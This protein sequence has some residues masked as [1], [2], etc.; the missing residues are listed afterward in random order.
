M[1]SS[2]RSLRRLGLLLV[3]SVLPPSFVVTVPKVNAQSAEEQENRLA[4]VIGQSEYSGYPL[5]NYNDPNLISDKL[6]EAGFVVEIGKDLEKNSIAEKLNILAEKAQLFGE[7]TTVLVYLSGRFAQIDG[8]NIFLPVG[9]KIDTASSANLNG[10]SINSLISTLKT[11]PVKS[12]VIILDG[13]SPP[14]SLITE[15]MFSPGLVKIEPPEGFLISYNQRPG[16]PLID[17]QEP[18]SPYAQGFLEAMVTPTKDFSDVFQIIRKRVFDQSQGALQP[19]SADNLL[20]KSFSFYKPANGAVSLDQF[21]V[22][23]NDNVDFKS[24]TRDEAYKKVISIDSMQSYQSFITAFPQDEAAEVVKYNLATRREAEVWSRTLQ[25]DTPE[26][27]WTYIQTYPKGN[28]VSVARSRLDRMGEMDSAPPS[29]FQPVIYSD[30]PPPLS[31]HEYVDPGVPMRSAPVAPRMNMSPVPVAVAATVAAVAAVAAVAVTRSGRGGSGTPPA[32]LPNASMRPQW[33]APPPA[34]RAV[35]GAVVTPTVANTS[36]ASAPVSAAPNL[37][38][39]A[40]PAAAS[41]LRPAVAPTA[42]V[43]GQA[44]AATPAVS[45][46]APAVTPQAGAPAA[47]PLGGPSAGASAPGAAAP[48]AASVAPLNSANP[49]R[50]LSGGPAPAVASPPGAAATVTP[51]NSAN[52]VRPLS[53]GPASIGAPAPVAAPTV[54]RISPITPVNPARPAGPA[55]GAAP[56]NAAAPQMRIAPMG[57]PQAQPQQAPRMAPQAQ[58]VQRQQIMQPQPQMR[59]QIQVPQR[60]APAR[61]CTPAM[62]KARQC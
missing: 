50:P 51:L 40:A 12:R 17:S 6:A 7:K 39:G 13:N 62:Q 4:L 24:M 27:Y 59:Q 41:G 53:G 26:A 58:P 32:A 44:P 48:G 42:P 47:R 46:M 23:D 56:V 18:T 19:F 28:N 8:N 35:T 25:L 30:L 54:G 2:A 34:N 10:I 15:K 20:A 31:G 22:S 9:A 21:Y 36:R 60:A 11:L 61:V 38:P 43:P 1:S 29:Q 3:L 45:N 37:S 33:A 52:P 55:P 16:V 5:V 57:V 49:V 14:Q